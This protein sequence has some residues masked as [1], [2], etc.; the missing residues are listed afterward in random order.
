M[1]NYKYKHPSKTAEGER[2]GKHKTGNLIS[3]S[4]KSAA[5]LGGLTLLAGGAAGIF[6]NNKLQ[7]VR[8]D[9]KLY[10]Q[11]TSEDALE[12]YNQGEIDHSKTTVVT[13]AST[14]TAWENARQLNPNGEIR[15]LADAI[16]AQAGP[17]GVSAGEQF[18]VERG[19]LP[20]T[21]IEDKT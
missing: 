4:R 10:Q 21:G 12:K 19:D 13:A 8:E 7:D 16:D 18:V 5:L 9:H 1:P 3:L 17:D 11:L 14:G 15:P 2:A 6:G 20:K